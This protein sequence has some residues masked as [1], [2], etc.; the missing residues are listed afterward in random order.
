MSDKPNNNDEKKSTDDIISE[1]LGEDDSKSESEELYGFDDDDK[2]TADSEN[3]P[4]T[5]EKV[6]PQKDISPVPESIGNEDESGFVGAV[7]KRFRYF[8]EETKEQFKEIAKDFRDE[9]KYTRNERKKEFYGGKPPASMM[10]RFLYILLYMFKKVLS[11]AATSIFAIFLVFILTGTIV[12]TVITVYILSFMDT[13]QAIELNPIQESYASYI[14]Q[15]NKETQEYE[16]VYKAAIQSH[17][18]RLAVDMKNLPDHVKYAF[19]CIEDERFYSHEGVDYKR[20]VGAI[21]NLAI[22]MMGVDQD[23]YGGSTITQQL[24]KNV[25]GE[26]EQTWERK[27][28]E[29]FTA[30]KF[31][32]KYTKDEILE[33]YLNEIYFGQIDTYNMYGIEA[34]SIG[35]FGKSA[36]ELTIAEAAMLA[37]IPKSPNAFNPTINP[38]EN[39]ER[40]SYCLTKM[41]ELGVIS[42]YEYQC[43][44]N[45]NIMLSTDEGFKEKFP[46]HKKLTENEDEFKN[47]EINSWCVDLAIYQFADY[48]QETYELESQQEGINMFNTG[49]YKLYITMDTDVQNHLLDTFS[50]WRY[51][52]E[53]TSPLPGGEYEMVQAGMAV[54]DYQGH[55]LGVAGK[56]GDKKGNLGWINEYNNNRQPGS[57]I[58]PI[59]TY[60]YALENDHITWSSMFYDSALPAGVA[61]DTAWPNNYDG[62]PSGG[63]YPV[64]YFLKQSINTLP[65]QIA[66]SYGLQS[67]FDFATQ[68]LGLPL[69]PSPKGD[70]TYSSL[71]VGGCHTSP[72]LIELANAYVPYGNGGLFYKA[73]VIGK[74]VDMRTGTTIID[75][76]NRVGEPAVSEETAYVMNK[77]LQNVITD[78]TGTAAQLYNTTVA[79]KTGTTENWRDI[80]FVG[81]TPDYVSS[82]WVGYPNSQDWNWRAIES[83]NSARIWYNVFGTFANANASGNQFPE[84]DSVI[85][86]RYCSS[87]G[88]IANPG[89]PGGQYGYYKSSN[90]P[91][92]YRH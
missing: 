17:D 18:I 35:Y 33:A 9:S 84:C 49:G 78:G 87:T 89:C 76:F 51:F 12:G 29:I 57:T 2:I 66:Y 16:L 28:K 21:L 63:Y 75:N 91:Y 83:A 38:D 81:L 26:D 71:C 1:I 59:T 54:L 42:P 34:A 80:T 69:N 22:T 73:S 92:C 7:K 31:E 47:P 58:K 53:A 70:L 19:V 8:K 82:L 5:E 11:L 32:K 20:T 25:T 15:M 85:Y 10:H 52:P 13:T 36:T 24:I 86:A 41:F 37:A 72:N 60:G 45:E 43:S 14:Y 65:A 64:S 40:R 56:I 23:I 61:S 79:G 3:H 55:I 68:N 6:E 50:D 48:L 27:M 88:C 62:K 30:M 67:V 46:N 77:L 74:A 4:V 39:A 44:L 90:A